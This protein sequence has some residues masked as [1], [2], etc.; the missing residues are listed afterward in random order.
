MRKLLSVLLSCMLAHAAHAQKTYDTNSVIITRSLM[1]DLFNAN[2][3]PF[4]QPLVTTINATSNSRFFSQAYVP[5]S[6]D[7]PYFRFSVH[8]MVGF[9]RDDQRLYTP[10][11]PTES[12]PINAWITDYTKITLLPKFSVEIVDTAGLALSLVKRLFHKGLERGYVTVPPQAATIFGNAPGSVNIQRDSLVTILT[13]D[14]EFSTV[15]SQLDSTNKSFIVNAVSKLPAALTLPPGQNMN[16][17]FAAVPQLEIGS[18]RGTEVLVRYVPPV[19][20]DTSVGDF[21][22]FGL[23]V[24]HS[25]SQYFHDPLFHAAVQVAYQGTKLSNTVGVTEARLEAAADFYDV[26]LH[27]S[28][29]FKGICEVYTG[30]D[31]AAVNINSSYTYVLPQEVQISLGLLGVDPV[32]REII[33]DPSRGWPGD[34][35][36]QVSRSTFTDSM[37]KWTVGVQKSIGRFAVFADYSVSKFNLFTGGLSY[38]F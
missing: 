27:I 9:V 17:L 15:F 4:M 11:L 32:T 26:N 29:E 25:L 13:S 38:R 20:W 1:H 36:K 30:I 35:V 37:L 34:D 5:D 21:S 31:Y 22:F 10:S 18:W 24:K 8:T 23:A 19:Q 16:T 6:V 33:K 2:S 3:I 12:R 7:K 14:P 28:K